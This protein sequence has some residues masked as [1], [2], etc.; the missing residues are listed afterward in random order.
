TPGVLVPEGCEITRLSGNHEN[1]TAA[2]LA[3]ADHLGVSDS[4]Y[5]IDQPATPE[6]PAG[7]LTTAGVA[8]ALAN[9]L[10]E[11][12]IV[13]TDS[14]GGGAAFGPTRGSAPHTWLNLTG[15]S[16][17]QGGPVAVGAAVAC[18]DR[19]VF[20]LIGDGASMYTNQAFWTQAREGLNVT[21][22]VFNNSKYGI[23]ETEYLRLGV[24]EVGER[25]A[26]LFHLGRPAI[27][28]VQLAASMG[29]PGRAVLDVEDCLSALL[30]AA[31]TDGP[32]VIEAR[33]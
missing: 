31:A 23:L 7:G 12:A 6:L 18:P 19:A 5:D 11:D 2:L 21:S 28:Y 27:D 4:D 10:P 24:N 30:E 3:I 15:G 22:I 16:I 25:A 1:T 14:G 33:L 29:V 26:D 17:G 13:C 8:V 32:F 9:C 20:A